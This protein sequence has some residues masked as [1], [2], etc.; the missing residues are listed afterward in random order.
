MEVI[1]YFT[2]LNHFMASPAAA[3]LAMPSVDTVIC[4]NVLNF[5]FWASVVEVFIFFF[6][7]SGWTN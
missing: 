5:A 4:S 2:L 3:L 1:C 6:V 7:A